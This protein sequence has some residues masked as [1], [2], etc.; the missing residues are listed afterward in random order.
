M[1]TLTFP[2]GFKPVEAE[3]GL[4][5][6]TQVFRSPLAGTVQT[7]EL[8][9][10]RWRGRYVFS[11]LSD[12]QG[13]ELKAFLASLDGH[14]GRFYYGDPSFLINGPS[15]SLGG[16]PL[17]AGASQTGRTLDIDGASLSVTDWG[18]AGDYFQ[19]T[20]TAGGREMK[21]LTADVDTNGSGEATLAF[22]P[23]IRVSPADNA[24]LTFTGATC[25]MMLTSP[26]QSWRLM[27]PMFNAITIEAIEAFTDA[28]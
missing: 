23:A 26:S 9:G 17:V 21:M 22:T 24:A 8:P 13:R 10:S 25:Q 14:A 15:G 3:F 2:S 5:S 28:S 20:N 18:K 12:A 1:T 11:G 6:N 4:V 16:T 27:Q 7:V 19:F